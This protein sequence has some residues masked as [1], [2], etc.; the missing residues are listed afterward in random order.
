MFVRRPFYTTGEKVYPCDSDSLHFTEWDLSSWLIK[1]FIINSGPTGFRFHLLVGSCDESESVRTIGYDSE[2]GFTIGDESWNVS[3]AVDAS[4]NHLQLTY[5][6]RTYLF[7]L[8]SEPSHVLYW[9]FTLHG[10]VKEFRLY[11]LG[12]FR[13][14]NRIY[15][16]FIVSIVI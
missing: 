2:R 11:V 9:V 16:N 10:S 4:T 8:Q 3:Q 13:Y 1:E 14:S 6:L 5:L 12:T 15:I 7:I